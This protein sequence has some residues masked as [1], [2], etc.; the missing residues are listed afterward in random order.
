MATYT[1]AEPRVAYTVLTSRNIP[2][3]VE[4]IELHIIAALITAIFGIEK[5]KIKWDVPAV[6]KKGICR[7]TE[8]HIEKSARNQ[9]QTSL[10]LV[11]AAGS[12]GNWHL[13]VVVRV[14]NLGRR[15][16]EAVFRLLL[17][18]LDE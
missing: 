18:K 1:C 16:D 2:H 9:R 10:Q 15:S 5:Q 14:L 6:H 13:G 8:I 4:S 11:V 3:K 7:W 12:S 17:D